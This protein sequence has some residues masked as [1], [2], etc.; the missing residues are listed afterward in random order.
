MNDIMEHGAVFEA[1]NWNAYL[2]DD[3]I[4]HVARE[5]IQAVVTLARGD[6]AG[7]LRRRH[8]FEAFK[9]N[10][11]LGVV[12]SI[13]WGYPKG[14]RPGGVGFKKVFAAA[15]RI[16]KCVAEL[17]ACR[18]S[19][20]EICASFEKFGDLGPS[21]YT[22]IAYFA[23]IQTTEGICLI[24]DQMV[25]RSVADSPVPLWQVLRE[26]LGSPRKANGRFRTFCRGVHVHTYGEYLRV[27]G[28]LA[29]A[30]GSTP[31]RIELE[32]FLSAPRDRSTPFAKSEAAQVLTPP[33]VLDSNQY[34][35]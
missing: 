9:Q 13:M 31:A 17:R 8:V 10:L 34:M 12:A 3:D 21:T 7:R 28:N 29:R 15:E 20:A 25:M 1:N 23:G 5:H 18:P 19:A 26:R 24:Y 4:P 33:I 22:K 14:R 2:T 6:R 30:R 32:L 35:L 11:S 27:A 16:A